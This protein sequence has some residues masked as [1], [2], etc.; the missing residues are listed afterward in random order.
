[1]PV[2]CSK[3]LIIAPEFWKCIL[4]GPELKI[5]TPPPQIPLETC[6]FCTGFSIFT[7]SKAFVTYF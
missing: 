7:Y 2:L 3:T 5:P 6:I 1:M 4:R